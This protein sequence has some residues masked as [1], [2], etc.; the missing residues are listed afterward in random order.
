MACE[1]DHGVLILH[2]RLSSYY[3]M[4]LARETVVGVLGVARVVNRVEVLDHQPD[5]G[6]AMH[7]RVLDLRF[8]RNGSQ[9]FQRQR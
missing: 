9:E 1:H 4:E 2:R 6:L 7:G 3:Q 8:G 5:G